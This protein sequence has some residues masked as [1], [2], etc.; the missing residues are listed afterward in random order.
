MQ[1][2]LVK[3]NMRCYYLQMRFLQY[4]G[5]SG[6]NYHLIVNTCK[7]MEARCLRVLLHTDN[8]HSYACA[9]VINTTPTS[10]FNNY[11]C[12]I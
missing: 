3:M 6:A 5:L 1:S 2:N 9:L 7:R 4:I 10:K 11:L 12:H 8:P